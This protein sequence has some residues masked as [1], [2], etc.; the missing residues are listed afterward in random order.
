M[1]TINKISC[2]Q[3]GILVYFVIRSAS[4]GMVV[5]S[6]IH[7]GRV[8]GYLSPLIGMI[9]GFIPLAIFLKILN[10]KPDLNIYEKID[11]LFGKVLG[12]IINLILILTIFFLTI[13]I[14]WDLLNFI[15]S[16]Y[17][18]RTPSLYVAIM[19]GISLFYL[20]NKVMH[21]TIKVANL[22]FYINILI[23][24]ICTFGLLHQLKL[25]NIF[26]FLENGII[27]PLL[28]GINNVAYSILPLFILLIIPKNSIK[29]NKNINKIV[30]IFYIFTNIANFIE[31]FF[32]ISVFGIDIASLYEFPD[33][34]LLR[35]ISTTG[36]FQRFESILATQWIFDL[37]IRLSIC[38]NFIKYGYKHFVK[39]K[40]ETTFTGILISL[41]CIISSN[42]L[43]ENNTE[44]ETFILYTLPYILFGLLFTIPF[45]IY[46]KTNK[47]T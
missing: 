5:S 41:V 3:F 28:S 4:L 11:H 7:I 15:G 29:N 23:F 45:I 35:R 12:K 2:F 31:T 17:L 33:F 19:F 36:F 6:N 8:D 9:I 21:I 43:F 37:F 10:Y 34:V 25:N 27:P 1:K 42:Y 22:L 18:F 38:F 14:F 20:C 16:Q 32:T 40:Y 13:I 39:D 24:L 44:G 30:I 47:K 26:P 46:L